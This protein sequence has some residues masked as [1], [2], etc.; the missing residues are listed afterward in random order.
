MKILVLN[1]S[2]QK[3]DGTNIILRRITEALNGSTPGIETD[4]FD[5]A[6]KKISI[7]H[8][9]YCGK[10]KSISGGEC[11]F[12]SAASVFIRKVFAADAVVIGTPVY[13]WGIS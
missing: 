11:I 10:C 4:K 8:C 9:G 12:N 3:D 5:L 6:A 13:P 2:P 7:G 1:G